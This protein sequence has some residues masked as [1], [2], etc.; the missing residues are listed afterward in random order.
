MSDA[1]TLDSGGLLDATWFVGAG[2]R[3][4]A[5][6]LSKR[7]S[8]IDH[9]AP[10]DIRAGEAPEQAI[11][12]LVNQVGSEEPCTQEIALAVISLLDR[13]AS[14]SNSA[15]SRLWSL[16]S[17]CQQVRLPATRAW[18]TEFLTELAEDPTQ[19]EA[20]WTSS[21]IDEFLFA[22]LT[23]LTHLTNSDASQ[24][25]LQMLSNPKYATLALEGLAKSFSKRIQYLKEWWLACPADQ[26]SAEL[27]QMIRMALISPGI[28]AARIDIN[29]Y[30]NDFPQ[31]LRLAIQTTLASI[32]Y[33]LSVPP[34]GRHH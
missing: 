33:P 28:E 25:W 16:L 21:Q 13:W 18:F 7:L 14:G 30:W 5:E 22:A 26:R 10:I 20:R 8:S 2:R 12:G 23:Q 1:P 4:I 29:Q 31:D 32:G 27:A 19:L 6:W 11:V 15:D 17:L 24:A 9:G 34:D 3:R